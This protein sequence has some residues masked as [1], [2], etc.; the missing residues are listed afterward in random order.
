MN[1]LDDAKRD[2]ENAAVRFENENGTSDSDWKAYVQ[3][4]GAKLGG[5]ELWN[6]V[7]VEQIKIMSQAPRPEPLDFYTKK[8]LFEQKLR[9][10]K[11]KQREQIQSQMLALVQ[12]N[13]F[14]SINFKNGE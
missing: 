3:Q 14:E 7:L 10:K 5:T 13:F 8:I 4:L 6:T 11:G 1:E 12:P 9:K 2:M